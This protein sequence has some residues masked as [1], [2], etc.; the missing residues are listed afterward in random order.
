MVEDGDEAVLELPSPEHAFPIQGH[1]PHQRSY[2]SVV[3]GED[4]LLQVGLRREPGLE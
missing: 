4:L 2:D 1:S 3:F